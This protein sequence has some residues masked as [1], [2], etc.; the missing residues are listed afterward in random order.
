MPDDCQN[1]FSTALQEP[2]CGASAYS[3]AGLPSSVPR[4]PQAVSRPYSLLCH[5]KLYS[6]LSKLAAQQVEP[7]HRNEWNTC[8]INLHCFL[9]P[10][11]ISPLEANELGCR[12]LQTG[13]PISYWC[14]AASAA[15][16]L[17]IRSPS[18]QNSS[19]P[20]VTERKVT[21][22]PTYSFSWLRS[23]QAAIGLPVC[24]PK[25]RQGN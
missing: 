4:L 15:P 16:Y 10:E 2:I 6:K 14:S 20:A 23:L 19:R 21:L 18:H 11:R 7:C 9:S 1:I 5:A 8:P 12:S 3:P 13:C 17:C 25:T 24:T 22:K